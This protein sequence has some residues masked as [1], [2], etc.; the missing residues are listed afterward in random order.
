M[1]AVA[2][3]TMNKYVEPAQIEIVTEETVK[4]RNIWILVIALLMFSIL[5]TQLVLSS[6]LREFENS[7]IVA[8]QKERKFDSGFLE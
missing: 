4:K 6:Y 5:P 1:D 8:Y 2:K 7:I 3:K